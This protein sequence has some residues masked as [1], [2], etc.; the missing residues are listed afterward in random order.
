VKKK[1][2][3]RTHSSA[4]THSSSPHSPHGGPPL[5]PFLLGVGGT[6]AVFEQQL[7]VLHSRPPPVTPPGSPAVAAAPPTVPGTQYE[8]NIDF[9]ND[10]IAPPLQVKTV[11]ECCAA[12]STTHGCTSISF[13]PLPKFACRLK[14]GDSGRTAFP[15]CAILVLLLCRFMMLL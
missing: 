14:R 7:V 9:K 12:C 6:D 3:T 5:Q 1:G 11:E 15:A 2:G 4:R 13:G 8:Q 10:D